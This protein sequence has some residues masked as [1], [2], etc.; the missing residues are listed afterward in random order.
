MKTLILFALLLCWQ[1]AYSDQPTD[2]VDVVTVTAER[3]TEKLD[4]ETPQ[5]VT[6]IDRADLDAQVAVTA[7]DAIESLPGVGLGP[8]GETLSFWQRGYTIRGL[9]AQ[10]VL[11]LTDG[12]RLSGQ[13][14][15]YGGGSPSLYNVFA[16]ERIEVLRG[17]NSVL[18]GTDAFGGVV[19][20]ITRSPQRRQ[21]L[22]MNG[23]VGVA[24]DDAYGFFQQS[25]YVDSG[26]ETVGLV[27][28]GSYSTNDNPKLADGSRA[29]SGA[30]DRSSVFAHVRF[31]LDSERT[32]RVIANSSR[33]RNV[34]IESSAIPFGPVGQGPLEFAF[35]LY[36][37]QL[38]AADYTRSH[39][40][41][42]LT[43]Y[44][45]SANHQ[46]IHRQFD[47]TTPEVSVIRVP[48]QRP[49]ARVD[50][51]QVVT[52][53]AIYSTEVATQQRWSIGQHQIVSGIDIGRD[54]SRG[55]ETETRLQL[56]PLGNSVPTDPV[57][58]QR[59]DAQQYRIGAYLQDR[60]S[61]SPNT[62][63]VLGS[64]FDEF[65]TR[66]NL[67]GRRDTSQGFS[68]TAA[69]VYYLSSVQSIYVNLGSG[70]RVPDLGE[71]YQQ[72][73]VSVVSP[74]LIL[75]NPE[76]DPERS[77]SIDIGFK[78]QVTENLRSE[79]AVF[80]TSIKDYIAP[81]TVSDDSAVIAVE[82]SFN[83]E[84]VDIWGWEL[85]A[86]YALSQFELS[87]SISDSV[88]P[89]HEHLVRSTGLGG[90]VAVTWTQGS[91]RLSVN[92]DSSQSSKDLTE[93]ARPTGSEVRRDWPG[94][95]VFG[96]SAATKFDL[97][98]T[99]QLDLVAGVNNLTNKQYRAPFLDEVQVARSVFASATLRF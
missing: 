39:T 67:T 43:E 37:R 68:G 41:R 82:Q 95:T 85:S 54:T 99:L 94:Y 70:F 88:S 83:T 76:L 2:A 97:T 55:P 77:R 47:R 98:S 24:Y 90:S 12:F 14:T 18:Y 28:G 33:D 65:R 91:T 34:E 10:R 78:G 66:D 57:A 61:L 92:M 9:G 59:V 42:L 79:A 80:Y 49:S 27:L 36:Q 72:S 21:E 23:A 30:T 19:N 6:V 29:T 32:V 7:N 74:V 38:I 31:D 96:V 22:G 1:Y 69:A 35:P 73:L 40:G 52:D 60:I 46:T 17:P 20:F 75:G 87:A 15:G 4:I 8:A 51:V 26:N 44:T 16:V 58:R 89:D 84:T 56:W 3:G 13:G 63:L 48:G 81:R 45:V 53:D 25:A 86:V 71:R 5:S 11:T 93:L 50:S 64:R 62:D